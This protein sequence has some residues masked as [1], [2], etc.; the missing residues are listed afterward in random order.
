MFEILIIIRKIFPKYHSKYV[1][2]HKTV[3]HEALERGFTIVGNR[4]IICCL[5]GNTT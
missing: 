4:C 1:K 2:I 5:N 3:S